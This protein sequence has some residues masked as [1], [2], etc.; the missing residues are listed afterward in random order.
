MNK[1]TLVL[2]FLLPLFVLLAA[3]GPAAAKDATYSTGFVRWRA[4]E[5]GFGDWSLSGVVLS[6][7]QFVLDPATASPGEDPYPPLGYNGH[8]FYNGG[9]FL[10]GEATSPAIPT[11][12]GFKEAIASWNAATPPG[13]WIETQIHAQIGSRWTKWYNLGIWASDDSTIERHSVNLQGD[14]DGFVGVDTLVLTGKKTSAQA[15]ALKFRLFSADGSAVPSVTNASVAYSTTPV[16]PGTVSAGNQANWNTLIDVP[17]CSQMVYEDGGEVWCSPTSTSMVLG[18]WDIQ[19][20]PCEPRVRAAVDGVF[21]WLYNG[22]GNWPFNT[23]YAAFLGLEGYV[24]RFTSLTQVEEWVKAGVPVVV[25]FAWKKGELTGA[26]VPSSNG[27]LA[28]II[29]FDS[30]GNPIVNDPAHATDEEVRQ[31]YLRSE[32]EPLWLGASG[33]TVYLIYPAGTE[34]PVIP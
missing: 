12:F 18:S 21:D 14:S 6:G 27:H 28:V 3:A 23:A 29:G 33:G 11:A 7:G 19:T 31:T 22:H 15:F 25:S 32:F 9:S 1:L 10:V 13:T 5:D 16:K 20:G 30:T 24:A 26:G 8:N 4:A 17:E 34:V 2:R